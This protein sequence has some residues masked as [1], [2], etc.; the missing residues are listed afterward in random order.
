[1]SLDLIDC[2][3]CLK[4][5]SMIPEDCN[6][7]SSPS[8]LWLVYYRCEL[9]FKWFCDRPAVEHDI[10]QWRQ[11]QQFSH[12]SL[13]CCLHLLSVC[14]SLLLIPHNPL[15]CLCFLSPSHFLL[16]I[17]LFFPPSSQLLCLLLSQPQWPSCNCCPNL[18]QRCNVE[19]E[20]TDPQG[21]GESSARLL[22]F[23][24]MSV[25]LSGSAGCVKS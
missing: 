7:S 8:S 24:K 10:I 25:C 23:I 18:C 16:L 22:L 15:W 14:S 4:S 6:D 21:S 12:W 3:I 13:P 9:A 19:P 11:C 17:F 1:M 2:Q 20:S 5:L